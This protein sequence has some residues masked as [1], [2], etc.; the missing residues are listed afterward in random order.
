MP[1]WRHEYLP[2][3]DDRLDNGERSDD[4]E[5][6]QDF[7]G[8]L[9]VMTTRKKTSLASTILHTYCRQLDDEDVAGNDED[10]W[11]P[12]RLISQLVALETFR[13]CHS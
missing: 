12:S 9:Y 13:R 5:P 7:E 3:V 11:S 4:D 1:S 2:H 10:G 6:P 8:D